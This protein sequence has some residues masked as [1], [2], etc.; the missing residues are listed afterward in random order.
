MDVE[1]L[2]TI[3]RWKSFK[4]FHSNLS[5]SLFFDALKAKLWIHNYWL[6]S[7]LSSKKGFEN[8]FLETKEISMDCKRFL[9]KD[10]VRIGYLTE[11]DMHGL[12]TRKLNVK[13][14]WH[15]TVAG[16]Q[17]GAAGWLRTS[18]GGDVLQLHREL[19]LWQSLPPAV[20]CHWG[21]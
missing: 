4:R 14:I 18:R 6:L 16:Q 1:C 3:N 8:A 19:R 2:E 13:C 12:K 15:W 11:K 9:L 5:Y 10:S 20:W 17:E 21:E 7:V